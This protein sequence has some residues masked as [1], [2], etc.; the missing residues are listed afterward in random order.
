MLLFPIFS[1]FFFL[2]AQRQ[3]AHII[4]HGCSQLLLLQ[5]ALSY[6]DHVHKQAF[7]EVL[8]MFLL[9]NIQR[10]SIF[11][12]DSTQLMPLK[13]YQMFLFPFPFFSLSLS[14]SSRTAHILCV[15]CSVTSPD[16]H[17]QYSINCLFCF[18]PSA[19]IFTQY[20]HHLIGFTVFYENYRTFAQN[21]HSNDALNEHIL[22]GE[23]GFQINIPSF[24]FGISHNVVFPYSII[25]ITT[26]N[27]EYKCVQYS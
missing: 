15:Q 1:F 14:W 13:C 25:I 18:I 3:H 7:I 6:V 26:W 10:F 27:S 20:A 16:W 23:N 19:S 22:N 17:I 12:Y 4:I 8:C 5:L 24:Q 9:L 11:G 21:I 2:S